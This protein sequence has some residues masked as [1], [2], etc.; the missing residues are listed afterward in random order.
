MADGTFIFLPPAGGGSGGSE[1]W[2]DAVADEAALPVG[3][4]NGQVRMTLDT[5]Q[6]WY[7][8]TGDSDWH[9]VPTGAIDPADVVDTNSVDLTVTTGVLS[10]DV[11][12]S[13]DA[14]DAGYTV[15]GVDIQSGASKGLRVQTANS[16]I[17]G[18]FSGTAPIAYDNSTGAISFAPATL[19]LPRYTTAQINALTGLVGGQ[20]VYDTDLDRPKMYVGGST[21][22]WV[23]FL[24]WGEP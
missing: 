13:S 4:Y 11:R 12:I 20:M 8:S 16:A 17:R 19:A 22:A 9:L 18:L 21:A 14:A 24:G 7:W 3:E 23:T 10:A 15:A 6:L 2:K 1:Y 5:R